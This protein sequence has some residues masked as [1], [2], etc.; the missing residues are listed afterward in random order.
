MKAATATSRIKSI[1]VKVN[2]HNEKNIDNQD[3]LKSK[4]H[5]N[6]VGDDDSDFSAEYDFNDTNNVRRP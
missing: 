4:K 2:I 1:N 6:G 5:N 3:C